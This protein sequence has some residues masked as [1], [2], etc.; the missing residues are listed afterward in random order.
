LYPVPLSKMKTHLLA[1][2]TGSTGDKDSLAMLPGNASFYF[3]KAYLYPSVHRLDME[4]MVCGFLKKGSLIDC[5]QTL[6]I[7]MC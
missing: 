2:T 7:L 3:V 6:M 4:K 5:L 1:S